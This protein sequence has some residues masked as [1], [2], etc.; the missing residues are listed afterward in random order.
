MAVTALFLLAVSVL[1]TFAQAGDTAAATLTTVYYAGNGM[2]RDCN[3]ASCHAGNQDWGEDSA[4]YTLHL[5][6]TIARDPRLESIASAL[7]RTAPRYP[8]ACTS[9]PCPSWSDVPEWDAIALMREYEMTHDPQA[10]TL[11]QRAFS[12]VEDA[13][14]YAAGACPQILYQVPGGG[15]SY[16]L[17]TLETGANFVKA[18]LLLYTYTHD[19]GYLALAIRNY[20][21]IRRYFL[22]PRVPLYSVYVFD[23]GTRCT[24]LPHRFF[25][26][27]NGDM[28][29]SG[30]SLAAFTGKPEYRTQAIATA[31][32]VDELL[33]DDAGVFADLQAEN[34]VAEPL[35][36]AMYLLAT[37]QHEAFA[38]E[39]ILH[40][41]HAAF[42][43]R[44]PDGTFGR[45]FD[46]P[47]PQAQSISIWQSNGGLALE[48]A[49]AAL[50]PSGT[51]PAVR[52]WDSATYRKERVTTLPSTISFSGSGIALI[53]TM[54]ERC[55]EPGHARVFIDGKETFDRTGIWQNKSM[56]GRVPGT[57]LFAW[58]WRTPGHHTLRFEPG[59]PNPKEGGPFLDLE[60]YRVIPEA[61]A[62]AVP[63]GHARVHDRRF[64]RRR[65]RY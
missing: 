52:D 29:W 48:I 13:R 30:L 41:A 36:E 43:E 17:K 27:V 28:I 4:T 45:F 19:R 31:R 3:L 20:G 1:Q 34:D 61:S 8:T 24:Q 46:G 23:D 42:E 62:S 50:D 63:Q 11:A 18:A 7:I 59:E 51:I 26:S 54:G 16:H 33:S 47:P 40:N 37:Q 6:W 57:V 65:D 32:A 10:L 58:R 53:G 2:W 49:A 55:C 5:R 39:W 25:A 60:G 22:D 35:V 15:S 64:A 56:T 38:R 44:A 9:L 12:F 14:V 21:V